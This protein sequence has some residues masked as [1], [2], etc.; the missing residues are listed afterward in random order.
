M[1]RKKD[2]RHAVCLIFARNFH[3]DEPFFP[4]EDLTYY[5]QHFAADVLESGFS[6]PDY[7]HT[8]YAG[9]Y[10]KL[11]KLDAYIT[12]ASDAWDIKRISKMDLTIMRLCLYEMYYVD[13]VSISVAINE[14]IEIAKE[15]SDEDSYKFVNGVLEKIRRTEETSRGDSSL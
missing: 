10:E 11:E 2:R 13:E 8:V 7:V 9:V 6:E 14:A 1:S 5:A 4:K 15:F 3:V 12:K